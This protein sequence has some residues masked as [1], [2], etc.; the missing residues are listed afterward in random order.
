MNLP[1]AP[2]WLYN[3]FQHAGVDYADVE[4]ARQFE[5]RHRSF[6][7]F[8]AEFQRI[9]KRVNLSRDDVVLDLGCGSGAFVIPAAQYCKK[10]YA[11]DVSAPMLTILQ[12]K[13]SE[14]KIENVETVHAGFLT[15]RHLGEPVDV[16]VSSIAL[17]HLP[18]YW[19]AV[20]LLNIANT[21][22]PGGVF[23]LLDVVFTFPISDWQ[24]GTQ[25]ILEEMS[26]AA[27]HEANAHISSE[28]SSF[29]WILEGILE[30]VG[31]KIEQIID[32][33]DFLRA[34]VCR[35]VNPV[36]KSFDGVSVKQSRAIDSAATEKWNVPTLLLMENAG[37]SLADVFLANAA[38]LNKDQKPRRVLLCCGKG[39]NGGDG[40][41]LARRLELEGIECRVVSLVSPDV[42]KGDA[43]V[44]LNVLRAMFKDS[45]EKLIFLSDLPN[46]LARLH[47]EITWC[48]WIVDA[49]LGTGASGP[50]RSPYDVVAQTLNSS[51]KPIYS[52]DLPSGVNAD[53]GSADPNA[54]RAKL[55]TTLAVAKTGLITEKA[56][57]YVGE[58]FIGDIG[59]P[60]SSLL[61]V[62][63]EPA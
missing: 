49:I 1:D 6:R 40:F 33:S 50:L 51:G 29:S 46:S 57:E 7:N 52:I 56:R 63:Q 37:R 34:Y 26:A 60:I 53:D 48:D 11:V 55:T 5:T 31:L 14:N 28:Y 25:T 58:L 23:Y 54:I 36:D 22:R 35:K 45:P 2:K 3:E 17:H 44:N 61:E 20:A 41:V 21:L 42:Y 32:D 16:V 18:D 9:R 59:V 4:V 62:R 12:E 8:E 19:K 38:R 13:L 24:N 10:V 39:N 27:G 30:R 47:S 15:Y 43:L